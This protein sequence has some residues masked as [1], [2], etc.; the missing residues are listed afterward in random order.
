MSSANANTLG[1]AQIEHPWPLFSCTLEKSLSLLSSREAFR[2]SIISVVLGPLPPL[3]PLPRA[4]PTGTRG[5]LGQIGEARDDTNTAV[6][7]PCLLRPF[8]QVGMRGKIGRPKGGEGSICC[9][10]RPRSRR[11]RARRSRRDIERGTARLRVWPE[12]P[13]GRS[14][15]RDPGASTVGG[16]LVTR[17]DST[18]EPVMDPEPPTRLSSCAPHAVPGS[19]SA[20][21]FGVGP[22]PERGRA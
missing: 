13:L 5:P 12:A 1:R 4:R 9:F 3:R 20:D 6:D 19:R 18:Q 15:R 17:N 7:T 21:A 22:G 14:I 8:G 11:A 2:L 10:S 16:S